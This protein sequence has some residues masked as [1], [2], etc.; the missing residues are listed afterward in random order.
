MT[1]GHPTELEAMT[2]ENEEAEEAGIGAEATKGVV[3]GKMIVT[4]EG[5]A[6]ETIGGTLTT[7]IEM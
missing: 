5:E 7:M 2:A 4:S 3:P 1:E 6:G